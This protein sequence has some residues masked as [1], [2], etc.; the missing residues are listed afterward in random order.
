MRFFDELGATILEKWRRADFDARSFSTICVETLME[1]PP[2][3]NVEPFDVV[4]WVHGSPSIPSQTDLKSKFGQ[5]AITV[6]RTETFHIDVLFWVDG[7]TAIHRHGFD[8]AFHVL[9]GSSLHSEYQFHEQRRY[10]ERL[11]AGALELVDVE[12]L[13][14][15]A[16]R[17]IRTGTLIHSLF[18]LDR[19][20]V[21][22]VVRTYG[23]ANAEPQYTYSRAGVAFDPFTRSESTTKQIQTLDLLRSIDHPEYESVARATIAGA[24]AFAAFHLLVHLGQHL[25]GERF[26]A[27]LADLP[28]TRDD[29]LERIRL[30]VNEVDRCAFLVARRRL[31]KEPE[32]RFLLALLLN[33]RSR[34]RILDV[35][36]EAIPGEDPVDVVIR[37]L[38]Q[39][40]KLDDLHGW[41]I[42]LSTRAGSS[43]VRSSG[44]PQI[45]DVVLDEASLT[46]A[47]HLL[48]GTADEGE[49]ATAL[50]S[51]R[52]LG[53]LFA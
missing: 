3:S 27:F 22:V 46:A 1:R 38:R 39:L 51:S 2:A 53:G 4:R 9:A 50:R 37:W 10:G 32:P 7:T 35:V 28:R 34:T 11:L 14:R 49:L 5:P 24:D 36:R 26:S 25:S 42:D 44:A 47:R 16:S 12:M 30:H 6:F 52:L 29:L 45:L 17:E 48:S 41:L 8:G 18:H 23:G 15:G 21:S 40:S 31:V 19:P 20:S 43:A 33:L 13:R